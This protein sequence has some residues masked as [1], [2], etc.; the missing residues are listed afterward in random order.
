MSELLP[1]D[2]LVARF[3]DFLR[4]NCGT[5]D[6]AAWKAWMDNP[7][8]KELTQRFPPQNIDK[9]T[10]A[11]FRQAQELMGEHYGF[12]IN[13]PDERRILGKLLPTIR[14]VRTLSIG[15]GLAPHEIY[16]AKEGVLT[17]EIVATDVAGSVIKRAG[18]I[19][20]KLG[21]SNIRFEQKAGDE[22]DYMQEFDQVLAMDS[23]HWMRSWRDVVRRI[24]LALRPEGTAT[25]LYSRFSPR[26][27]IN[28][29]NLVEELTKN[30]MDTVSLETM[31]SEALS[32]RVFAHA[33]KRKS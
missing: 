28:E 3:G 5:G 15:C 24:G 20:E 13:I 4:D 22:I 8:S 26:V 6:P 21:V 23:L 1:P 25:I 11:D 16:L 9:M 31:K 29:R 17:Q 19:A 27:Q 32:T 30:G 2:V 12:M 14:D 7:R 10:E 33:V 18:E